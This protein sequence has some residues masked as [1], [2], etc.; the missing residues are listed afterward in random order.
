MPFFYVNNR[1]FHDGHIST[2]W[3]GCWYI[4]QNS[5]I[6]PRKSGGRVFGKYWWVQQPNGGRVPF[7]K[8]GERPLFLQ[9]EM[10]N[11]L[12]SVS[13]FGANK[14]TTLGV[15]SPRQLWWYVHSHWSQMIKGPRPVP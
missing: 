13:A 9:A 7:P 6:L 3:W 2:S 11:L 10:D 15:E 14:V 1:I 5:H 4:L 8:R 12:K